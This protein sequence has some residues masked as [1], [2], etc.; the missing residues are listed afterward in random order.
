LDRLRGFPQIYY[1]WIVIAAMFTVAMYVGGAVFYGFTA[2]VE[3]ISQELLWS[4]WVITLAASLRGVESSLL[5][6]VVGNMVDRYGPRRLMLGGVCISVI[7]V[8]LLSQTYN[9][10]VYFAAFILITLG[11]STTNMTVVVTVVG[12]W[13][14][15]R[16]GL[17]TG[18][19]VSGFACG[20]LLVPVINAL[21]EAS[22][23]RVAMLVMAGGL[24]VIVLPLT[25]F[26][27]LP[28]AAHPRSAA[29]FKLEPS[30]VQGKLSTPVP[31]VDFSTRQALR[32]RVF[33]HFVVAYF[34][35]ALVIVSVI[36]HIM[37]YLTSAGMTRFHAGWVAMAM[38]LASIIGRL[39]MGWLAD[40]WQSRRAIILAFLLAALGMV[41]F[42]L[43]QDQLN[44]IIPFLLI[45]TI[46]YGGIISLRPPLVREYFGR[47]HFGTI[48][49]FLM[50]ATM[51][52]GVVGP[53]L[54]GWVFDATGSYQSIW[55]IYAALAL[56]GGLA[57]LISPKPGSGAGPGA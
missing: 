1:G 56:V 51:L 13:F 23:W 16:L 4:T 40:R 49:G 18:I 19:A 14:R 43:V 12:S 38:P 8:V 45:F 41:F 6:P 28:D 35:F 3:P 36:T 17:A 11:T 37:P 47:A 21:I 55:F 33:W 27:R 30:V 2:I 24:V 54:A 22:D 20:G 15:R 31:P 9:L 25:Y 57:I 32:S 52:G 48:F 10:P 5:A 42:G 26:I 44:W 39:G 53:P 29:E 34:S 50:A 46:G 7:G